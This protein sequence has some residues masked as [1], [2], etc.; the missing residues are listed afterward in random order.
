[1]H[2]FIRFEY[3]DFGFFVDSTSNIVWKVLSYIVQAT[4]NLL[5]HYLFQ[6]TD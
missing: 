2:K 4:G 6:K 5:E 1:M 3:E